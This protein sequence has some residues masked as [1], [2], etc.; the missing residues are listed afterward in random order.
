MAKLNQVGFVRNTL[1]KGAIKNAKYQ[2][3]LFNWET[4]TSSKITSL[5]TWPKLFDD[6]IYHFFKNID[7]FVEF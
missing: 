1:V 6:V 2:Q 7:H 4:N 3:H 5:K